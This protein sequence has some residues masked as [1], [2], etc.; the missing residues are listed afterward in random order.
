MEQAI[1][2]DIASAARAAEE[3]VRN[4]EARPDE[5]TENL[6]GFR[7][8]EAIENPSSDQAVPAPGIVPVGE[9]GALWA[10]LPVLRFL[11]AWRVWNRRGRK[12]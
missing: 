3:F 1:G 9:W 10:G 12:S 4:N 2:M 7:M 8:D 5:R 6:E 11:I